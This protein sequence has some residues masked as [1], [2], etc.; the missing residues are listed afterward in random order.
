MDGL[1]QGG[2]VELSTV[3]AS[4]AQKLMGYILTKP[5]SGEGRPDDLAV[6]MWEQD[7]K[8]TDGGRWKGD[9]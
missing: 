9:I 1:K 5:P 8:L 3:V 6:A 2:F 4:R 7:V